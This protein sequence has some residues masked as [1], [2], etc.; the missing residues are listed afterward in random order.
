MDD[1]RDWRSINLEFQYLLS[2][3]VIYQ[4]AKKTTEL[5]NIRLIHVRETLGILEQGKIPGSIN[6]PL[7]EVDQTHKNQKYFK[8]KCN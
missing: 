1:L 7:D 8:E 3:E 4:E 5:Q 6:I 2:Q